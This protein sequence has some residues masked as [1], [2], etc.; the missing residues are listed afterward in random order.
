[1]NFRRSPGLPRGFRFAPDAPAPVALR[2]IGLLAAATAREALSAGRARL[3]AGGPLAFMAAEVFLSGEDEVRIVTVPVAEI[4]GWAVAEGGA[5]AAAVAAAMYGLALPREP[6]AGVALDR[7][8]IMG[9]VNVTPDSFYDGGRL[10]DVDAAVAR[11]EALRAAGA[12]ILDVGGESTRPGSDPPDEAT[13]IARIVPVI[14]RLAKG[15][16][17]VSADTRRAAVMKA[18]VAAGARIVNDVSAL[19]GPDALETAASLGVPVVLMHMRGAPATMQRAPHYDHAPYE[20]FRFLAGRVA[21][22]EAAGIGRA[23]IAVD[24]G[25]GFGKNTAHNLAIYESLAL[26]HALGCA[27]LVG[28]SRKSLIRALAGVDDP[29]DRLPGSLALAVH[30]AAQGVQ[31]LRVHDVAE[32]RQALS[33]IDAVLRGK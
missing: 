1:M 21:A 26:Y 2:P 16:A 6:F 24:P 25:M 9:V 13:E 17:P 27:V 18:A 3:L 19:T 15:G 14:E 28:P 5:A 23:S 29:D 31:I 33:V 10:A 20:V 11:G 30:A 12:D 7:P 22:C 4:E 32:T 8:R